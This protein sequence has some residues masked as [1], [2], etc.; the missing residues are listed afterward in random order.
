LL[1]LHPLTKPSAPKPAG[2]QNCQTEQTTLNRPTERAATA[3]ATSKPEAVPPEAPVPSLSCPQVKIETRS[4]LPE[5][6]TLPDDWLDLARQERPDLDVAEIQV[7]AANFRDYHLSRGTQSN[8]WRH[9][10][11]R[12][13][14]R[15]RPPKHSRP[16]TRR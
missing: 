2:W 5:D 15:E 3:P 1:P 13:I 14:R 11:R 9:E 12:W 16:S 8:G 10:W 6:W 4:T 7:S